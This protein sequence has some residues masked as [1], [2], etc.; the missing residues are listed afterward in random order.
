MGAHKR[1]SRLSRGKTASALTLAAVGATMFLPGGVNKADASTISDRALR[2][3]ESKAGAPYQWGATGPYRF[4]CSGLTLYSFKHAGKQLPRT[5]EDQY[6]RTE[7][8]PASVREPG[9][10]VFFHR[11]GYVYHVGIYVGGGRILHAPH[12]GSVVRL[13]HIWTKS[14]WYG[15]VDD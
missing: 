7:H 6:N 3:A 15:R 10:L 8:I 14:V 13:E 1:P 4:D 5:A 9:D 11:G 12:T 2:I